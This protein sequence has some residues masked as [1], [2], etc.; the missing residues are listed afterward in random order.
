MRVIGGL[1][2]GRTLKSAGKLDLRPATDRVKETIFNI[3]QNKLQLNESAVLDLFAGTGSLGIEALS[4]GAAHVTFVDN[5][6]N[7]IQLIKDNIAM[8][9]CIEKCDLLKTDALKYIEKAANKYDLIFA[10]PPYA[11]KNISLIP[12]KIFINE[13]LKQ[14][15]FLVIEHS[16]KTLFDDSEKY[17]QFLKKEFGNTIVTFFSHKPL[18]KK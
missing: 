16:K 6:I 3:L 15:G 17:I 11:Y 12:E 1:Y 4:R 5:S 14:D 2:K 10:D 18:E 8:F 9:N 13:L 7:S